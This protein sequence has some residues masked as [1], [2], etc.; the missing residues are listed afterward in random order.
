MLSTL[1]FHASAAFFDLFEY[2]SFNAASVTVS[3][4]PG[5]PACLVI[6]KVKPGVPSKQT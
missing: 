6:N 4:F 2:T 5:I 3:Q 1:D